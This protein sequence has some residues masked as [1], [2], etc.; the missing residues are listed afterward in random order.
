MFLL[1]VVG[2]VAP[3]GWWLLGDAQILLDGLNGIL[4]AAA[5]LVHD[6]EDAVGLLGGQ[7]PHEVAG[8][9]AGLDIPLQRLQNSLGFIEADRA[10]AV[11]GGREDV[12][13][14]GVVGHKC[15][16]CPYPWAAGRSVISFC[17]VA[18][19]RW[20]RVALSGAARQGVRVVD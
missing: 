12:I 17:L 4:V 2:R 19:F 11:H 14:E 6:P 9:T 7:L 20:D 15:P 13:V 18:V 8:G 16:F 1:S 5:G 3:P 10:G